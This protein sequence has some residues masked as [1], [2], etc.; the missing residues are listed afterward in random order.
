M[1]WTGWRRVTVGK[2]C[3]FCL[4]MASRGAVYSSESTALGATKYHAHCDCRAEEVTEFDA[5]WDT[6][7]D[8]QDANRTVSMWNRP[9]ELGGR[10]YTYDLSKYRGRAVGAPPRPA[11]VAPVKVFPVSAEALARTADALLTEYLAALATGHDSPW[12]RAKVAALRA[13]IAALSD[14]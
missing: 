8:P 12:L 9:R 14:R 2:S 11:P 4:V 10:R 6:A 13:E 5:R 3:D 7:I 1:A